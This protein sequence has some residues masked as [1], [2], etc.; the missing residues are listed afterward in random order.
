MTTLLETPLSILL[1]DPDEAARDRVRAA[2]LAAEPTVR[3]SVM[4]GLRAAL[5]MLGRVSF[6]AI[7][8]ELDLPEARGA[9]ALHALRAATPGIP[10]IVVAGGGSEARAVI[11]M[12]HGATDYLPKDTAGLGQ[13]GPAVRTAVGRALLSTLDDGA[14]G[15]STFPV[16]GEGEPLIAGARTMRP[17]LTLLERASRSAVPVLIEGETGTGKELLAR[18]IHQRGPRRQAPFLVQN[19]AAI[20]ESLLESELFGH[21]RGAFTGADRDR[22]G[23]FADAGDGTVLLDEIAD[24]PPT[25]QAKLLRVLQQ[26]EVKAVGADRHRRVRARIIAAT[27][28]RLEDEVDAGRFRRDLY[29]RLAVFPLRVPPLRHRRSDILPLLTTF[30]RR[31]EAEE[32]RA[33]GGFAPDALQALQAYGWPGNVRELEHEVHRLVLTVPPGARVDTRHLAERI[34]GGTA[35]AAGEPLARVLARVELAILRDRIEALPSKAAA[36]RSLGITREAL[37]AKLRRL[38]PARD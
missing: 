15:P 10:I 30:L 18:A 34:R 14:A 23:L 2:L 26:Y 37:Y 25:V 1:I 12:R 27:N 21:L 33:T 5:E 4:G 28:R 24:A 3:V 22:P 8:T 16:C 13:L 38:A 29:Y 9:A 35:I 20:A 17:V 32:Q 36:A 11:A 6:D 31:F 19:C 7:V